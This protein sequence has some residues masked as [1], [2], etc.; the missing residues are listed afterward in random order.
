MKVSEHPVDQL[1]LSKNLIQQF[2][3]EINLKMK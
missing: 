3:L 2:P 1:K